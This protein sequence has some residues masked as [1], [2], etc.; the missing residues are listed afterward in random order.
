MNTPEP[1]SRE[2][3]RPVDPVRARRT[4]VAHLVRVGKRLGYGLY[5]VAIVSFAIGAAGRFTDL[6]VTVTVAALGVGSLVLLPSIV[7]GYAVRA[8][9]RENRGG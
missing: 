7:M 1:P 8:A 9:E 6:V 4:Q 2:P 3:L 5:L